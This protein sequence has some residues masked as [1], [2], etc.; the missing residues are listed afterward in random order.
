[1]I[2]SASDL[3]TD[4]PAYAMETMR[5]YT[6]WYVDDDER[7]RGTIFVDPYSKQ[8]YRA[9]YAMKQA[10][11]RTN[12]AYDPKINKYRTKLPGEHIS[13]MQRYFTLKNGILHYETI[14]KK[15]TNTDAINITAA[16]AHKGGDNPHKCPGPVDQGTNVISAV[17]LPAQ[18]GMYAA[19]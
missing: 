4:Q 18:L 11:F 1:M 14:N 8:K 6:A 3:V 13:T 10:L 17:F 9:G 16:T 2:A 12:H 15:I 5:N 19:F 7:E